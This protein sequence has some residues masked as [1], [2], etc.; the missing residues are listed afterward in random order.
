[1]P[2]ISQVS[3]NKIDPYIDLL[4]ASI[5]TPGD[6]NYAITQLSRSFLTPLPGSTY[7]EVALVTGV[8][9]N[10]K[11]EMYRRHASPYEDSAIKRNGDVYDN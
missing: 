11:Q 8:L 3:R 7:E 5:Q 1:M 2:Y 4:K 10:V 9:E 6:L